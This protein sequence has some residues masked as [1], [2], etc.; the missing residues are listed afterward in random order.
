MK[1]YDHLLF[2]FVM[3][4]I[5]HFLHTGSEPKSQKIGGFGFRV[6]FNSTS[7][8][9]GQYQDKPALCNEGPEKILAP[10]QVRIFI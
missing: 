7:L 1:K 3:F 10:G 5:I 9:S 6:F 2:T 8:V 4:I